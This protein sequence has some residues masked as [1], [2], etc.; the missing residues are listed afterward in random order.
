MSMSIWRTARGVLSL[1]AVSAV[2]ACSSES[3]SPPASLG[4]GG[5]TQDS[6]ASGSSGKDGA[7]AGGDT[8]GTGS[9]GA[10]GS[11]G[12]D[13]STGGDDASDGGDDGSAADAS[14]TADADAAAGDATTCADACQEGAAQCVGS[15][16]Q[17][18]A[19]Q[20]SGCTNWSTPKDC[21]GGKACTAD[22]CPTCTDACSYGSTRCAGDKVETCE[23]KPS[24]C[25]DW[26]TAAA[27]PGSSVCTGNACPV[28]E[29]KCTVGA[30]KCNG[31]Q[32]QSCAKQA[33][34]C[35]DWSAPA[36]CSNGKACQ[37]DACPVCTDDCT[38]NTTQCAKTQEQSCALQSDGCYHWAAAHDCSNG[39]ACQSGA[40]P[41]C[42]DK[43][44]VADTKC[45]GIQIQTCGLQPSGCNDWGSAQNCPNAGVCQ[46]N[47]CIGSCTVGDHRCT[48]SFLEVCNGAHAWQTQQVCSQACDPGTLQCKTEASCTAATRRCNGSQVQVCNS[49]GSAWLTSET[50]S[51]ACL[52][53]LC[54]GACSPG[55]RRCNGSTPEVC[56][57]AGNAWT[58]EAACT[59]YCYGGSC[60]EPGL[61]VDADANKKLD[62]EHVIDGDVVIKNSSMV[63]VASGK[64]VL[65]AKNVVIDATSSIVVDPNGSDA[66]G[67]G[68]DGGSTSCG[69][70][71]CTATG[72]VGASGGGYGAVGTGGA[73]TLSCYYYGTSTC[74]VARAGGAIYGIADDEAVWGA[75]GGSCLGTS[76]GKGGGL[77]A[78]Y[79]QSITIQGTITANGQSGSGCA[80][81]GSGGAIVLRA[82]DSLTFAGSAS[83][84]GGIGGSNGAGAGAKGVI[85]FL[86]GNS[87]NIAGSTTGVVFS[88]YVPPWDLTSATHPNPDR[89][90]NDGFSA[91]EIAWS[92]PFSQSGGYY[93]KLNSTYGF[94]PAPANALYQTAETL[95]YTP[96]SLASGA[97]Y[98]HVAVVGASFDPSNIESRFKVQINATA[99][100][101]ASASHPTQTT[102]YDNK[103]AFLT[104]TLPHADEDTSNFYWV[105]DPYFETTPTTS[106][107]PIPMNLADPAS[108]K[109]ILVPIATN[110]IWF[111]HLM[112]QDTMGNLTKQGARFKM[113]VGTDPGVG[114]VSGTVT[115]AS[116][117][118]FVSG[119]EISLNRGVYTAST[120]GAGAYAFT[121]NTVSA[122]TYEIRARKT[123][124]QD[125]VKSVAVLPNQTA[126]VNFALTQ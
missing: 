20:P 67:K 41:V 36:N 118:N 75:P 33:S 31:V 35:A 54:T 91:L 89:W 101:I 16:V 108:S 43:C 86:Y 19:K 87:H 26:G 68:P 107:H 38:P 40:C 85:K 72:T 42:T 115:D 78:I 69:A 1:L 5:S 92:R 64:L 109:R 111:F 29:D 7:A 59:T 100:T 39:K 126:T 106:D 83:V 14:G 93:Y 65:R 113:L 46:S 97:N 73:A 24:G 112:A 32:V 110:G 102:W 95:L 90:Y 13:A 49:T 21:A 22:A 23:A 60:A 98:V 8:G 52:N 15:Q 82:T 28:C 71:G 18:C 74:G 44:V 45:S 103:S 58:Q 117:G 3:T 104:W 57:G 56:N 34:T 2:V 88:S 81:G 84:A 125:N 6:G 50:C 30:T 77:L 120:S 105:L 80:G 55:A 66:R 70:S 99:P 123:G 114:G 63:S 119:V 12:N 9:S 51:V 10:G 25:T 61:T 121:N 76:G 122:Q 47:A 4:S 124:Y 62:G 79:A 53:G 37:A 94:V 11:A 27:C 96:S 48:G 17:T 116:N